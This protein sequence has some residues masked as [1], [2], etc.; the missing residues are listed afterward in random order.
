MYFQLYHFGSHTQEG[1]QFGDL[2]SQAPLVTGPYL[3]RDSHYPHMQQSLLSI[4]HTSSEAPHGGIPQHSPGV[5]A[6]YYK[7]S[8][9][10]DYKAKDFQWQEGESRDTSSDDVTDRAP[11]RKRLSS[12][13]RDNSPEQKVPKIIPANQSFG[14][15]GNAEDAFHGYYYPTSGYYPPSIDL[16]HL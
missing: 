4:V 11:K 5:N 9:K 6:E 15:Y 10:V 7:P 1:H 14:Y 8:C 3:A 2:V 12:P 16:Q 13:G